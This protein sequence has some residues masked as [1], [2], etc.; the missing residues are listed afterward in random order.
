MG[1]VVTPVVNKTDYKS[2]TV[3]ALDGDTV[4]IFPHGFKQVAPSGNPLIGF[5][6]DFC[7]LQELV[8]YANAADPDWGCTC[9]ATNIT[10]TKTAS[11]G[12]GGAVAGTTLIAKVFA[13]RPHSI[14]E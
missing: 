7:M 1:I 9:D 8:S 6:P 4:L 10:L 5:A 3:T 12:S 13:W 2:W 11:A 14:G